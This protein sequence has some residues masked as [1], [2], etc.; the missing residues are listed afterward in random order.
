VDVDEGYKLAYE[1]TVRALSHQRDAVESLRAHAGVLLSAAAI[2]SSLLG[3]QSLAAG[4]FSAIG[5]AA[6]LAF[7]T[8]G[9]A[10]VSIL[11]P[12]FTWNPEP[13]RLIET[14]LEVDNPPPIR[15]MHRELTLAIAGAHAANRALQRGLIRRL[16][17]GSVFLGVEVVAWIVNLA[18]AA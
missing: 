5:W 3:G 18:T 16:Q 13:T 4:E 14:F 1:E 10:L 8:A 12:T 2:T 11:W 17:I 9:L 7:G 15:I 6:I